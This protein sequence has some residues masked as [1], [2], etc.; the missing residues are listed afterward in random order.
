LT[1]DA[2]AEQPLDTL[3]RVRPFSELSID[4]AEEECGLPPGTI[5]PELW[6]EYVT[7]DASNE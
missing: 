1:G 4:S 7:W 6:L 3:K 5:T 2:N